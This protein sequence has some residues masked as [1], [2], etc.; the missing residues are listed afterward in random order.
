MEC[1][2]A[3]RERRSIRR[4]KDSAVGKDVIEELLNA[5]QMAPSAG[6]LQAR[7]FIVIS[8]R[9][10][11]RKLTEAALNQPFIEEAPIVIVGVANIERSARKYRSR[12]ELYAIQDI[13]AALMN[14]L[15]AAHS[16]GLATCWVGA[17]DG[18]AV[19]EL[20]RLPDKARP[21]AII[22]LGYAD[23]KPT[24]PPR[25]GLDKVVHWEAW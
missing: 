5:A 14:L 20:L 15:L 25:M 1:L 22:P 17:F 6:N 7:D 19:S 3:I 13:T 23:E 9:I 10:I 18:Y 16:R 24:A 4:F 12:G 8:D 11:K 2:E 21:V